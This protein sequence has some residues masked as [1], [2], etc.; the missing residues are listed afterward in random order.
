MLNILNTSN[1]K[2]SIALCT[3]NGEKYLAEQLQSLLNQ[4]KLPDEIVVSDDGSKD[5]TLTILYEFQ[6]KTNVKIRILE[7]KENLGVFKNFP[8]VISACEGDIIFTCDQDDVWMNTKLE[9]HCDVHLN[10]P[11]IDLVY[12]NADVVLNTPDHYLYPLWE[13]KSILDPLNGKAS[14]K[15]LVIK[16]QSIAGCCMSFKKEFFDKIL[17]IPEKI[18]HDDWLATSACLAG[19]IQGISESLIKYRQHGNNVVGIIRGR[20]LSYY[21]S[22]FTNVSFYV[23]SDE[24]IAKRHHIIYEAMFKHSYLKQYLIDRNINEIIE[25]YDSRI[26]YT[27]QGFKQSFDKL[28]LSLTKGHYRHLNGVLT[29]FKD[30]YNLVFIKIMKK[31]D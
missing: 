2:I 4:T 24:Y 20:K 14:F 30:L 3:Y 25:L 19:K 16:G 11:D 10:H 15:S 18:F 26:N 22:L 7:H 13:V 9:K 28:T 12:S 6:A 8:F 21:K 23:K 31:I 1:M 27:T 5:N 17:P 29:Y